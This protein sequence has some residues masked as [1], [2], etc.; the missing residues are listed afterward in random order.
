MNYTNPFIDII[1]D[2]INNQNTKKGIRNK[3]KRIKYEKDGNT[4]I[5]S[6]IFFN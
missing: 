3:V 6:Q 4:E 1:T 2:G 5:N